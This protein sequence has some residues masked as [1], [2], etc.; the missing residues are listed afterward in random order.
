[1]STPKF[2]H[3]D[4]LLTNAAARELYHEHAAE[5]PIL[6]F[7]NH[8]PADQIASNHNFE[9]LYDIWL[10]GDHY[11]WRAM[12]ANGIPEK[13]ITGDASPWE[14]FHAYAKTVP[15]TLRNP[16][17]H[18]T[19]LELKRFFGIDK[20][21]NGDTSR[22]IWDAAN[23]QLATPEFG[24]QKLLARHR[25]VALCTTDCPVDS[26]AHHK[27]IADA[28]IPLR[29]Y[30]TFRP[31]K[32]LGVH[33]PVAFKKWTASLS[34]TS[35]VDCANFTGFTAALTQRHDFFHAMG[36]RLSDHGLQYC[37]TEE[38]SETDAATIY[39]SALSGKT[40]S[41]E[42]A[43]RFVSYMMLFFG[44]LDASKSWT[45]QLHLGAIRNNNSRLH[46]M[47]GPD[48]G[49]DSMGDFQ[50]GPSLSRYLDRLDS[51]G[52][53]PKMILYNINPADNYLFGT[54]AGN[55]QDG[56]VPGKIQFGAAWW[57]LDQKEG[58]ELQLN[59]LSNLGLLRRFVGM[60]TDSRSFLSYSRHEYFRRILCNLI[61]V[62]V[63]NGELPH[64]MPLLGAMVREICFENARDFLGLGL[65]KMQ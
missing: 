26:L 41:Q 25:V 1:M 56:V 52:E 63:T 45:K 13:Y 31:D 48:T 21:L 62:D 65:P 46:K 20:I 17:Y 51:T 14:K 42:D 35:G 7:H 57:F 27:A 39:A 24:V 6:D 30:P 58:I 64:D 10:A 12:R 34:E 19:H 44:R 33:D 18:W 22:E 16:L 3:N 15:Y 5:L 37:P 8:L 47:L 32:A 23:E 36:C 9:T 49:F 50:Q 11:K 59:A 54:M 55:F 29:V 60:I 43:T 40:G 53:L 38:C 28:N 4:F 61:G 2:L